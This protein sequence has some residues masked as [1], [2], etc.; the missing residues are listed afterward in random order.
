M[1]GI[2]SDQLKKGNYITMLAKKELLPLLLSFL[3]FAK[4][5]FL[6]V[7]FLEGRLFHVMRDLHVENY[8]LANWLLIVKKIVPFIA[9]IF[10]AMTFLG[11]EK[12]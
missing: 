10:C 11:K 7:F 6:E 3:N 4:P 8:S 1:A 5:H 2:I 9:N 12:Y